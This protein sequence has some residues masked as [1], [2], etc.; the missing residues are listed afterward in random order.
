MQLISATNLLYMLIAIAFVGY[1]YY[2][3]VGNKKEIIYAT[4]RMLSQLLLIGYLLNYIFDAESSYV[5][6]LVV[7]FMISSAS[8]IAIR[9]VTL[10]S[11]KA[12]RNIFV[13]ILVGG[14]VNLFLVIF[15]VLDIDSINS[16]R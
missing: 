10:K 7:V 4:F 13:A 3:W 12:Y 14:S 6:I 11:F 9:N 15:F 8:A 16:P 5:T 2:K 1:F